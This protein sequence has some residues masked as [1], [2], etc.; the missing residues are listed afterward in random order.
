MYALKIYLKLFIY[1][2]LY[3]RLQNI[4]ISIKEYNKEYFK[5]DSKLELFI[6]NKVNSVGNGDYEKHYYSCE[7]V[8]KIYLKVFIHH[9]LY[10]WLQN[11]SIRIKKDN[12]EYFRSNL[13]QWICI[14]NVCSLSI[15]DCKKQY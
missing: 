5:S 13:K 7:Y 1:L 9:D 12:K 8:L 14:G 3:L 11:I 4:A 15:R 2:Y 10:L 6:G